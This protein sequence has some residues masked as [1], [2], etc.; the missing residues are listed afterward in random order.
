MFHG[1]VP[2]F[3]DED[4]V[5]VRRGV[6]RKRAC[7]CRASKTMPLTQR[8]RRCACLEAPAV[9]GRSVVQK[10]DQSQECSPRLSLGR[11]G[12]SV[13]PGAVLL[14]WLGIAHVDRFDGANVLLGASLQIKA[15]LDRLLECHHLRGRLAQKA[16][17]HAD[18]RHYEAAVK[19]LRTHGAAFAELADW[20]GRCAHADRIHSAAEGNGPPSAVRAWFKDSA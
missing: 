9:V 19:R 14:G 18:Q 15:L 8:S 6:P 12:R 7:A 11:R 1:V 5:V 4:R 10:A 13:D 3:T 17:S 2:L 20:I 16:A